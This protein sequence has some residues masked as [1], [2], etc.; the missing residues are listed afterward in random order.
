MLEQ[1]DTHP[2]RQ[3]ELQPQPHTLYK[4]L[5]KIYHIFECKTWSYKASREDTGETWEKNLHDLQL[6]EQFLDTSSSVI[7]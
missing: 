6:S 5:L 7:H 4:K 1:P 3:R 2:W